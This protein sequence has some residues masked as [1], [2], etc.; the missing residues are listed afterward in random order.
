M[1]SP[2]LVLLI[3]LTMQ[4]YKFYIP[5]KFYICLHPFSDG[6][7]SYGLLSNLPKVDRF[8]TVALFLSPADKKRKL[9][10]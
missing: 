6:D 3:I 2:Q 5:L 8:K 4:S 7:L 1:V 9:S 10:Q